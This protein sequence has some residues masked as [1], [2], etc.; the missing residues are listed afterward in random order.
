[1]RA[2]QQHRAGK[3]TLVTGGAGLIGSHLSELLLREGYR[4]RIL[5][6]LLD[7]RPTEQ[8]AAGDFCV[9]CPVCDLPTHADRN[10]RGGPD[11]WRDGLRH[12]QV[13]CGRV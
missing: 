1:M 10:R 9:R 12:Y 2:A 7:T 8:L 3:C 5:D 6:N 4:V 11:G 13:S